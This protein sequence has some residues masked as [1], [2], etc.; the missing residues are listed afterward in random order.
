MHY[1]LYTHI[2]IGSMNNF[3][4]LIAESTTS[5]E[6]TTLAS[7]NTPLTT[8]EVYDVENST[9]ENVTL[10]FVDL[11]TTEPT[12][13]TQS[14]LQYLETASYKQGTLFNYA[15]HGNTIPIWNNKMQSFSPINE[16]FAHKENHEAWN[17]SYDTTFSHKSNSKYQRRKLI[18]ARGGSRF[19]G[20]KILFFDG[21]YSVPK[22]KL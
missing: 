1:V 7:S 14:V 9:A 6:M 10:E 20:P 11:S 22:P 18:H 16:I 3:E 17:S 8:F 15:V 2:P 5:E 13:S 4:F 21:C 19:W 12:S